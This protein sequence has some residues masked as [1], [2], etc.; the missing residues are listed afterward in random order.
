LDTGKILT[1]KFCSA[2]LSTVDSMAHAQC[3][4]DN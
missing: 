1:Y 3:M 2:T 4:L